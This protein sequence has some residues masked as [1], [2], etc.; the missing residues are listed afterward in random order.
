[1]E[2]L[3]GLLSSQNLD[4][5]TSLWAFWISFGGGSGGGG[6]VMEASLQG[7]I[8]SILGH[9]DQLNIL[10]LS[11]PQRLGVEQKVLAL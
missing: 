11:A 3:Y 4:A 7:V 10:P 8:E 5:V 2:F 6:G 1:M 9:D